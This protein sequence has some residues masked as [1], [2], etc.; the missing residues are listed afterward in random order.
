MT[1]QEPNLPS[2]LVGGGHKNMWHCG[3]V[4]M[5]HVGH[6]VLWEVTEHD[7]NDGFLPNNLN[8]QKF[9]SREIS[10]NT[11][12]KKLKRLKRT[13]NWSGGD[14]GATPPKWGDRQKIP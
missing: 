6:A 3:N 13:K 9:K 11:R 10:Q 12:Q 5:W 2:S 14:E 7:N 1:K 4:I 8:L